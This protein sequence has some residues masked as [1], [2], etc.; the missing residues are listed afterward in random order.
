MAAFLAEAPFDLQRRRDV[1]RMRG[2]DVDAQLPTLT[3]VEL[4]RERHG[5]S[6]H[7]PG[8]REDDLRPQRVLA[9]DED[10][11]VVLSVEAARRRI[12]QRLRAHRVAER[13]VVLLHGK[14]RREVRRELEP[15]LERDG[16]HALVLEH[17]D[18]LHPLSDEPLAR[19][20]H[21]VLAQS[22]DERIAEI[23][24][25]GEVFD[26][27]RRQRQRCRAVHRQLQPR[28]EA[29]VLREEAA[30]HLADV[31][32][33]VADAEGRAFEDRERHSRTILAPDDCASAITTISSMFTLGG[34]ETAKTMQSATSSACIGPPCATF[35]YTAFAFSSSPPKRTF[36]KSVSTSP[37]AIVVT[38]TGSPSKSSRRPRENACTAAFERQ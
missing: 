6:V 38:R 34:R 11:L 30:R 13:E 33:L 37:G 28:Q 22:A 17:E 1:V 26:L 19:D 10:K 21:L 5:R 3:R 14:D 35:A 12:G 15:E 7:V 27:A 32:E 24:R 8:L 25:R 31:A 4:H 18:V 16:I 9:V 20:R 23:E 2:H 36:E 29:C